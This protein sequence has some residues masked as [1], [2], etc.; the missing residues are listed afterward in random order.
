MGGLP[1]MRQLLA[2]ACMVLSMLAG[3]AQ[4]TARAQTGEF[5]ARSFDSSAACN[6]APRPVKTSLGIVENDDP[7]AP[8]PGTPEAS[9][10]LF[11]TPPDGIACR[12]FE[13]IR[14]SVLGAASEEDW[15]PLSLSTFFTEG[16]NAPYAKSPAGTNGT[17]RQNWFGAADGIFSRLSSLNFFYTNGMTKNT[18]LL[19][20]PF[21]WSPVK[22]NASGNQYW[23]SY[24][25]YI[26]LNQRLELLVV[27]PFVAANKTPAGHY[28]ANFGDLTI[29]ER[30]RLVE[31]RNFSAQAVLTERTPTGQTINGN[32]IN[33]VS[34]SLEFWWNWAPRW[35]LRGGT[36][37]NI[38]TGRPSATSTYF[39]N[40][41]IGR[42]LTTKDAPIFKE[43]VAHL[44]I[45][46]TSDIL[47]RKNHI[48]DVYISPGV[49]FGLD[50]DQ[51]WYALGVLQVPV[52]G[53]QPY[54]FQLDF[55]V[56]RNY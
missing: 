22:P 35:V 40:V 33:F 43:L 5:L 42:Y 4:P 28:V 14:E 53:P 48:T 29:S 41:A 49:R 6:P 12:T 34:P 8:N 10:S 11:E 54:A 44:G 19:L 9:A 46:T 37:V 32:N 47:G 26:P 23:A 13:V 31:Q 52:S 51:K 38:D 30:F 3:I 50:R 55:A 17:P 16:W 45:S 15:T 36:G 2:L 25:L 56:A 21:P 39:N 1:V 24:N 27:V 7:I 20:N 18:G